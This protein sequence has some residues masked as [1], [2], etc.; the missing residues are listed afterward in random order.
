[1]NIGIITFHFVYNQG[2][3]L[4]CFALKKYLES[5]GH[6]VKVINYRPGYHIVRYKSFKNPVQYAM[7][8]W[9]RHSKKNVLRRTVF[10]GMSVLRCL[11]SNLKGKDSKIE[12]LFSVF[13][14]EHLNQTKEY[15]SLRQLRKNPP[16]MD[17]YISGSDQLWNPEL[18]DQEFDGAYFLEFG[19]AHIPRIAYAVSMGKEQKEEYRNE[20]K[21]H[22]EGLTAVSL[23]EYSEASIEAT[24]RDVHVCVD[25]TFLINAEDYDKIA[26]TNTETEPYIFV[27]GFETT[28]EIKQAVE[29]A[30]EKYQ[31]RI[32]NGSPHR[33]KLDCET[34]NIRE[35]APDAFLSYIKNAVCVI[36]NSFHATVFS[37][38]YKKEFITVSHSTRGIRMNELLGKL[39]LET[40]L[41]G[42]EEFDIDGDIPWKTA[43]EKLEYHRKHSMEYLRLALNGI[44]GEDIQ[45]YEGE[46]KQYWF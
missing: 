22:C 11:Y 37:I 27:Y 35:Y 36:T 20:L 19:D 33:V 34:K 16:E 45:H 17:A 3:V 14:E 29:R 24:G 25:P 39:G 31:C 46:L 42:C 41:W 5:Q 21:K 44:K 10:T 40:R 4:Q 30:K 38:I 18:L 26:K 8:N 43:Q 32:I 2:A 15:R 7:W 23:R 28:D 6:N 9:K 1:M 13:A 12:Q